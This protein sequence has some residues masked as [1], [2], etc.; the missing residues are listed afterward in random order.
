MKSR[1][2]P[3]LLILLGAAAWPLAGVPD[4]ASHRQAVERLFELTGM[5]QKIAESVD[6]VLLMQLS[7]NPALREH[8]DLVHAFLEKTI[9]WEGLEDDLTQMYLETFT[10][11]EINE[12][13]AFYASPTGRKLIRQLPE[14]VERRNRL[15]MQRLQ[16]NIGELQQMI[17][18][19]S[20]QK[21]Q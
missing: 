20:G 3:V 21:P 4:E 15:A 8:Q 11:E 5:Q 14:L 17:Q 13:N 12:I 9:G 6:N 18:Q 19:Q 7:Q 16:K 10:E 2:V 1:F